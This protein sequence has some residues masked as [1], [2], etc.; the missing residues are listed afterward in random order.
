M[1]MSDQPVEELK[2]SITTPGVTKATNRLNKLAEA[3]KNVQSS[4][5]GLAGSTGGKGDGSS[6]GS[7][8]VSEGTTQITRWQAWT[9]KLQGTF[10][11]LTKSGKSFTSIFSNSKIGQFFSS[12]KRIA[13]YRLIRSILSTAVNWAKEGLNN[14]Y[15][16]SK[17]FGTS[18]APAMDRIASSVDQLKN[19]LGAAL[20]QLIVTAEP[21][22][23]NLLS[24]M[25]EMTN[26]VNKMFAALHGD[27]YYTKAIANTKEWREENE[28]LKKSLLGIDELNIIG[29]PKTDTSSLF[30]QEEVDIDTGKAKETITGVAIAAGTVGAAVAGTKIAKVAMLDK[31]ASEIFGTSAKIAEAAA[32]VGVALEMVNYGDEIQDAV[33][34]FESIMSDAAKDAEGIDDAINNA[35]L[36]FLEPIESIASASGSMLAGWRGMFEGLFSGDWEKVGQGLGEY[37]SGLLDVPKSGANML[38]DLWNTVTPGHGLDVGRMEYSSEYR[39]DQNHNL[40]GDKEGVALVKDVILMVDNEVLARTTVNGQSMLDRRYGNVAMAK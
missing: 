39:Y 6:G 15:D 20:A 11:K 2:V 4:L 31:S 38:S 40:L 34:H 29:N 32:G 26:T 1:A 24:W 35:G 25:T 8:A 22:I 10:E 13:L 33:G 21:L 23:Q 9:A 18:F 5:G 7:S 16:Y 17:Q 37:W 12:I 36:F 28:K 27:Q 3:A 30:T 14:V 19:S